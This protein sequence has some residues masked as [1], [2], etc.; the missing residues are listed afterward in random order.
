M[1][2]LELWDVRRG[3]AGPAAATPREWASAAAAPPAPGAPRAILSLDVHRSRPNLCA[4]GGGGGAVAV[5]DLRMAAAPLSAAG[6]GGDGDVWEVRF[7]PLEAYGG[8]GGGFGGA[9]ALAQA[10]GAGGAPPPLLF[11]TAAGG[12]CR[13]GAGGGKRGAGAQA[14]G[15]EAEVLLQEACSINSFD[16]DPSKGDLVAVTDFEGLVFAARQA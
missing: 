2:G 13:A 3:G 11:C 4:S 15:L 16:A 14:Q 12:L 8:G 7:D 6:L 1:G 5:W 9:D 10:A